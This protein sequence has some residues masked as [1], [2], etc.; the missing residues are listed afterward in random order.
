[1]KLLLLMLFPGLLSAQKNNSFDILNY[2]ISIQVNDSTDLIFGS[3]T[4]SIKFLT[5]SVDPI[6]L[7]FI[8]KDST[9][10]GMVVSQVIQDGK[11]VNFQQ[12][13]YHLII[14]I[15]RPLY[16][17]ISAIKIDY[18]GVPQ[19]GLIISNN[20]F[21]DRTFFGDNWP[22][23]AS[24]WFPCIDHP[25]EKATVS[26]TIAHPNHYTCVSNGE[27]KSETRLN[28]KE[29]V[30]AYSSKFELP[31]KVM[32][33]GLAAFSTDTLS[34]PENMEHI[35]FVFS[36]NDISGFKD[37]SAAADPL[38]FF[39]TYIAPYPFEKLYNVQSTTRYGGMENAGCIFYDENAVTGEGSMEN[40]IAHEIAHQWFGNS[41]SEAD[42]PH[43]WLSEGFATYFTN[44]HIE[45]KYGRGKMN[46]QLIK[47]R[48]R[49]IRF[50]KMVQLP[51]KDT[52]STNPLNML[53][54][55]AYQRGAWTLHMLRNKIGEDTFWKGVR[56]YYQAFK[57]KNATTSDLM[58][59]M[60]DQT[61]LDLSQFFHQWIEKT[62][63]PL[64]SSKLYQGAEKQFLA[65]EQK[66][67]QLFNFPLEVELKGKHGKSKNM[68]ANIS[69]KQHVIEITA[70]FHI[71]SFLLDPK[72]KLLFE[73]TN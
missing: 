60:Q 67:D 69:K 17:A 14:D 7:D 4:L 16:G 57:Y 71:E 50:H 1:M 35:N 27:K 54:P 32:V 46:E 36:Q 22:N 33:F 63:H 66:Q 73:K 52:V 19:D 38:Q 11:Q 26:F 8:K 39:E 55:N 20:K 24:H 23:R 44:L 31:T 72:T 9:E 2:D 41:A 10:K 48:N 58:R 15:E 12:D 34:H 45:H 40:L 70:D 5:L 62:G 28:S 59:I 43:L 51:L 61:D 53:N 49:V 21:G 13:T 42:W 6:S 37:M 25:S 47:D 68:L 65:I 64:L 29:V 30:T 3:N 56:A 18:A